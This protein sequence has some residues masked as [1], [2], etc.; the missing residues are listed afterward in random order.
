MRKWPR[1]R[2]SVSSSLWRWK[3]F[4][5]LLIWWRFPIS[6][7]IKP[8]PFPPFNYVSVSSTYFIF[9]Q[10]LMFLFWV[11][12]VDVFFPQSPVDMEFLPIFAIVF[13]ICLSTSTASLDFWTII[14][15]ADFR[16]FSP[17]SSFE[18]D[19]IV[20]NDRERFENWVSSTWAKLRVR[21]K[22]QTQVGSWESK[23]PTPPMPPPQEIRALLRD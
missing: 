18:Q 13:L 16:V 17:W 15:S 21:W 7:I 8:N 9:V 3:I 20:E 6:F 14:R 19:L 12:S 2:G 10:G 22:V 4:L 5:A 11:F 1:S 23:G